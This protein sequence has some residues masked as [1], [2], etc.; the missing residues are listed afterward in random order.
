[1][2]AGAPEPLCRFA[3]P[4][5]CYDFTAPTDLRLRPPLRQPPSSCCDSVSPSSARFPTSSPGPFTSAHK[6][7]FFSL[8]LSCSA[9][10]RTSFLCSF[11]PF[12]TLFFLSFPSSVQK[13]ELYCLCLLG[14]WT[15]IYSFDVVCCLCLDSWIGYKLLWVVWVVAACA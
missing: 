1:M 7:L 13:S 2:A 3:A 6:Y 15:W 14:S 4:A 11:S 9:F 12:L 8:P 5:G 10:H